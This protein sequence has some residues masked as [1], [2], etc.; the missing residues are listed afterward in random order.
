MAER[1]NAA[2]LSAGSRG[3]TVDWAQPPVD[4]KSGGSATGIPLEEFLSPQKLI[5][6]ILSAF[7]LKRCQIFMPHG[8]EYPGIFF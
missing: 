7:L 2:V 1:S 8:M 4:N 6:N 5:I 3:K